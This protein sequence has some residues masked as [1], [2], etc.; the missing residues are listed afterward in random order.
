MKHVDLDPSVH[1]ISVH[2]WGPCRKGLGFHAVPGGRPVV[3][4]Y[5]SPSML[6]G[7]SLS[8]SMPGGAD[9]PTWRQAGQRR[10]GFPRPLRFHVP[11]RSSVPRDAEILVGILII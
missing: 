10:L 3:P 1:G 2:E 8:Y 11:S 9:A 6:F 7:P 5:F 4:N